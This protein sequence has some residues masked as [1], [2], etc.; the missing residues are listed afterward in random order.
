MQV[1]IGVVRATDGRVLIARRP[2]HRPHGG[3]WEFPGGKVEP[4]ET[5]AV[6][7]AREL[8]EELGIRPR[9]TS[10]LIRVRYSY[11]E[12]DVLLDV[13]RIERY[14]G[15]PRA[16]EGQA[17]R[18]VT[19]GTLADYAYPAANRPIVTAAGLPEQYAITPE[20]GTAQALLAGLADTL[21]AGVGLVQWR[22]R[23]LTDGADPVATLAA[24]VAL[25]RGRGARLVVN[26]SPEAALEVG[27]H[28]IHLTSARLM[29]L[30]DRPL[31]SALLV[32]ASCHDPEEL[33][34]A[35]R[36]GADFAVL[37]PVLSTP[38]HPG[39]V[40]LGWNRFAAWIRDAPLPVYALGGVGPLDLAQ[41]RAARAQ[42]VAGIRALWRG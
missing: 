19:P 3:L 39:I 8:D 28:G 29:A 18:W 10:P 36:I 13:H 1:A 15:E 26:S 21:A 30:R 9:T 38:S 5:V 35:H 22:V 37:S 4:G 40:P 41:A 31:P 25:C 14:A 42:G 17:W 33:G 32:G 16:R 2:Q 7:L 6:A 24:A 27:A 11:P 20:A 34:Q 12:G 23:R